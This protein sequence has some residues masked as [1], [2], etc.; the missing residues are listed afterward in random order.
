[1]SLQIELE[2][3]FADNP[4]INV[5]SSSAPSGSALDGLDLDIDDDTQRRRANS[6]LNADDLLNSVEDLLADPTM[7]QQPQKQPPQQQQQQQK[8]AQAVSQKPAAVEEEEDF[9]YLEPLPA[10]P[11]S[12]SD[13][14][15]YTNYMR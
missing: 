10:Q 11:P 8:T 2:D 13:T 12:L 4:D 5:R 1:L 9:P 14:E 7:R 15:G 6:T 3:H